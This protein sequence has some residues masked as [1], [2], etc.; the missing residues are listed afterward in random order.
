MA[1]GVN[2][3]REQHTLAQLLPRRHTQVMLALLL[4]N[5]GL[6]IFSHVGLSA[7]IRSNQCGG[8]SGSNASGSGESRFG[9]C[10][11]AA[12]YSDFEDY[13]VG[14]GGAAAYTTVQGLCGQPLG[15]AAATGGNVA[16]AFATYDACARG[17]GVVGPV[18]CVGCYVRFHCTT[19]PRA[20]A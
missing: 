20:R 7:V 17:A 5:V 12:N 16:V 6:Q 14:G 4:C 1:L 10:V 9:V 19:F 11:A 18:G 3:A 13:W 15:I 8:S 2:M